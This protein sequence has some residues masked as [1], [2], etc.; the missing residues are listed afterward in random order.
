MSI[1][2]YIVAAVVGH[3]D[4]VGDPHRIEAERFWA[5]SAINRAEAH[6]PPMRETDAELHIET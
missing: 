2:R 1:S 3:D 6:F 5:M 4:V